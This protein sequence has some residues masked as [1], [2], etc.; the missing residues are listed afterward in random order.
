MIT[1]R[2]VLKQVR[3]VMCWFVSE[4]AALSVLWTVVKAN[5][6]L[7]AVVRCVPCCEVN[8]ADEYLYSAL[9]KATT[10]QTSAVDPLHS[11]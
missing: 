10:M 11:I 7:F 4:A 8:V 9:T 3:C 5:I 1:S 6:K 2:L